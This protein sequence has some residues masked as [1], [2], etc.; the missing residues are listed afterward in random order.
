MVTRRAATGLLLLV[1]SAA[2]A[3][4][5]ESRAVEGAV[6]PA[7]AVD[8]GAPG[9]SDAGS[10]GTSSDASGA[11]AAAVEPGPW[12]APPAPV[13]DPHDPCYEIWQGVRVNCCVKHAQQHCDP[14]E[15]A[16]V[17]GRCEPGACGSS[18]CARPGTTGTGTPPPPPAPTPTVTPPGCA[19]PPPSPSH[20]CV[21]DCG[22]V[23]G[24][25]GDPPP[26]WSWLTAAQAENRRQ[27]GCPICLPHDALIATLAASVPISE[28]AP[29]TAVWTL[30]ERGRRAPSR[31]LA[32]LSTPAPPS[33]VLAVLALADGRTLRASPGHPDALGRAVGALA[34][35]DVLDGS[36]VRAIRAEPY[37][38]RT[39]DLVLERGRHYWA[40]GVLVETSLARR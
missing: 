20:V 37:T 3:A 36:V 14:A 22:P 26:G 23:V 35:G 31:V 10:V 30:D 12:A 21:R 25:A 38:G 32:V 27:Y 1:A 34:L 16:S 15:C 6:P 7:G 18:H 17:G 39:Y 29:G 24:R 4:R 19:G 33:H 8:A 9:P 5:G 2:C 13:R 40:D 28:L 11:D